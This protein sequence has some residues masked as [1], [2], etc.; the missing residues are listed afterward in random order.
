MPGFRAGVSYGS[1][2]LGVMPK[3]KIGKRTVIKICFPAIQHNWKFC[4]GFKET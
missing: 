1:T 4:A 3:I 2:A